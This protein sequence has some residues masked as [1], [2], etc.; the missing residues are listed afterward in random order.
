MG[1]GQADGART[2][3]AKSAN[4]LRDGGFDTGARCVLLGE[5]LLRLSQSSGL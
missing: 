3:H 2:T 1:F 5:P 4:A